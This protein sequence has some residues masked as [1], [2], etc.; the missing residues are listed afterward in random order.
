M[1][2]Q[3]TNSQPNEYDIE[4]WCLKIS[5]AKTDAEFRALIMEIPIDQNPD[6]S[7]KTDLSKDVDPEEQVVKKSLE[8]YA[9]MMNMLDPSQ[10]EPLLEDDFGYASQ[11]VCE[12]ITSKSQFMAYI[13][14]KLKTLATL[15]GEAKVWAEL[16]YLTREFPGPCV[17]LA[18]GG[19]D[20]LIAVVLAKVENG[21]LVRLDLCVAPSPWGAIRS[22]IYPN[23][24]AGTFEDFKRVNQTNGVNNV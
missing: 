10:L 24:H 23:Q 15:G 4:D 8:A 14:G 3:N 11:N 18:Q 17:V 2:Q 13:T 16:G 21:R 19:K 5:Q 12:E 7:S 6:R 22:G 20:D 1:N 9:R